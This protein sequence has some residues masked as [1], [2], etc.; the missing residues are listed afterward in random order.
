MCI[1]PRKL[2][3]CLLVENSVNPITGKS[4]HL[5]VFEID[6]CVLLYVLLFLP[7]SLLFPT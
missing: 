5:G 6:F 7:N 3:F 4:Y 2:S 1:S